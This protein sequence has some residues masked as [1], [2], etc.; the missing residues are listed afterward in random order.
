MLSVQSVLNCFLFSLI[1]LRM[2]SYPP[3]VAFDLD[4]TVWAPEMY[5]LFGGG[6]APF[7]IIDNNT[8]KD[9]SGTC[10]RLIGNLPSIMNELEASPE[11]IVAI[12]SR[13][14]EPQW[15]HECMKSFRTSTGRSFSELCRIHEI[16]KGSKKRHLSEI[17]RKSGHAFEDILFF[18][19]EMGNINDAKSLGVVAVHCPDG[20]TS[21]I[22]Q[23]GL[24]MWAEGRNFR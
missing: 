1:T 23:K 16:Y 7:Q 10:V 14:D 19:N 8:L 24:Q 11:T 18:D 4:G 13:T 3:V 5:E 2:P 22:W 12:A 9:R 6:G 17:A 15:A 20:V 21:E